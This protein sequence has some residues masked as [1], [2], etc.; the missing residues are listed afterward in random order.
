MKS[1]KCQTHSEAHP[2]ILIETVC[3]LLACRH[4]AVA[5]LPLA[6]HVVPITVC[7]RRAPEVL[8]WFFAVAQ[9]FGAGVED[10]A[11]EPER[12]LALFWLW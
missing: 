3:L 2:A 12:E 4:V 11:L 7:L 6:L 8:I 1:H 5:P 9:E 10:L